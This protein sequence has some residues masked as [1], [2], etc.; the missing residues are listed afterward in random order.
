[1]QPDLGQG[2]PEDP[3]THDLLQG[4]VP[5]L[6]ELTEKKEQHKSVR[7]DPKAPSAPIHP[8]KGHAENPETQDLHLGKVLLQLLELQ[9]KEEQLKGVRPDLKAPPSPIHLDK[10]Q[11]LPEDLEAQDLRGVAFHH[12]Q[13]EVLDA[14]QDHQNHQTTHIHPEEDQGLL[15]DLG[16]PQA[17]RPLQH[18]LLPEK[19]G[20]LYL[21]SLACR[22]PADQEKSGFPHH[23]LQCHTE[24]PGHQTGKGVQIDLPDP[25]KDTPDPERKGWH[26]L[27]IQNP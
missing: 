10:G 19:T 6:L 9:E 27:S 13:N 26:H 23:C 1:M 14:F 12:L 8:G 17:F 18:L 15:R 5:L 22:L 20:I 16:S 3:L 24:L 2:H 11:G 21:L 7:P 4:K 25:L